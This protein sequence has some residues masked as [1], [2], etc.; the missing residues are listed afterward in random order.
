MDYRNFKLYSYNF[1]QN[2]SLSRDM[3]LLQYNPGK[4]IYNADC[5]V[6]LIYEQGNILL[7]IP[8]G[9]RQSA[10]LRFTHIIT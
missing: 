1:G 3:D 2:L 7:R 10:L 9:A 6:E 8:Y 4:Y 5:K